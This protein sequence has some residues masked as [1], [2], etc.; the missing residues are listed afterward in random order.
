MLCCDG[1]RHHS[2]NLRV[3]HLPAREL[4]AELDM[5]RYESDRFRN[6]ET[7]EVG[8]LNVKKTTEVVTTN[9]PISPISK[10]KGPIAPLVGFFR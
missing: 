5:G 7:T 10:K 6:E 1:D 2:S 3:Y 4:E 9:F 8:T